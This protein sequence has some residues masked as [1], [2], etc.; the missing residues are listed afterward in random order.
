M[1]QIKKKEKSHAKRFAR[2]L[3][4][5]SKEMTEI[6]NDRIWENLEGDYEVLLPPVELV[7]T[8]RDILN[9]AIKLLYDIAGVDEQVNF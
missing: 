4:K 7:T 5:I 2:T 1:R 9:I 8:A 3:K 6:D